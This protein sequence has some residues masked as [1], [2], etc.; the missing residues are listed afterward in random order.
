[1]NNLKHLSSIHV[2]I[3][4]AMTARLA[5]ELQWGAWGTALVLITVVLRKQVGCRFGGFLRETF[6][7]GA[8]ATFIEIQ[9]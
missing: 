9:Q 6:V 7:F 8:C 3:P 5:T 4:H 1:M 2:R